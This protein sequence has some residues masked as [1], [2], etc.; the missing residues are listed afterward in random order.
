MRPLFLALALCFSCRSDP[1]LTPIPQNYARWNETPA[2]YE[3]MAKLSPDEKANLIEYGE[4]VSKGDLSPL[5]AGTTIGDALKAMADLKSKGLGEDCTRF[6]ETHVRLCTSPATKPVKE[7]SLE[8]FCALFEADREA[9]EGLSWVTLK[10]SE[11]CAAAE[12]ILRLNAGE[13]ID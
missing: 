4:A 5:T 11:S 3:A 12:K 8:D 13:K 9:L 1:R 10:R 6:I 7:F 2:F